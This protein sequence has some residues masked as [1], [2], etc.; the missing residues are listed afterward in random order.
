MQKNLDHIKIIV[1][2]VLKEYLGW[3]GWKRKR[4]DKKGLLSSPVSRVLLSR[5][6]SKT[7]V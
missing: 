7:L 3:G 5:N 6:A 4:L 2:G 1:A